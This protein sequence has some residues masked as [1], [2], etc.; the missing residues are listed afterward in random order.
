[1]NKLIN[2]SARITTPS[3]KILS[4]LEGS[5]YPITI[6]TCLRSNL[7]TNRLFGARTSLSRDLILDFETEQSYNHFTLIEY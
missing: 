2:N 7:V 5:L 3:I 1:M 4:Y 6:Y